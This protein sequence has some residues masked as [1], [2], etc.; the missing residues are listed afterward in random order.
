MT[1][2]ARSLLAAAIAAVLAAV[3][4]TAAASAQTPP[5]ASVGIAPDSPAVGDEITITVTILHAPGATAAFAG[6]AAAPIPLVAL[7]PALPDREQR[8]DGETRL[9]LRTQGFQVGRHNVALPEIAVTGADGR[10]ATLALAPLEVEIVSILGGEA[11]LRPNA[12]PRALARG[13]FAPWLAGLIALALAFTATTALRVFL[14]RRA[15]RIEP[16]PPAEQPIELPQP[17]GEDAGE[18]CR[19]LSA[20]VRGHLARTW[21]IPAESL[22]PDELQRRLSAAGAPP[23]AAERARNLLRDC[24]LARFGGAAPAPG[25]LAGYRELARSIIEEGG[26]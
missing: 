15:P 2:A 6:A 25:R 16:E 20:A 21:G 8:G 24:D 1:R 7:D 4:A 11:G 26:A 5:A 12:P 9:S 22:T 14:R 3:I 18:F 13:A 17:E 23:A 19:R 10:T